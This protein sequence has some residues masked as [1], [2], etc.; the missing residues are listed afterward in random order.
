MGDDTECGDTTSVLRLA[1]EE[2]TKRNGDRLENDSKDRTALSRLD[3]HC[4]DPEGTSAASSKNAIK[5]GGNATKD[6]RNTAGFKCT[7][8]AKRFLRETSLKRHVESTH[9]VQCD[10]CAKVFA[11]RYTL[12]RHRRLHGPKPF[13]CSVCEKTFTFSYYLQQHE[14]RHQIT[15]DSPPNRHVHCLMCDTTYP[16]RVDL[17]HH[18]KSSHGAANAMNATTAVRLRCSICSKELTS[19]R[20]L[21]VHRLIHDG[22]RP[23][24]CDKCG[25]SFYD[26][27]HLM[28]HCKQH[29]G[30][31][32]A[33][34]LCG[35][36]FISPWQ[37]RRHK[38]QKHKCVDSETLIIPSDRGGADIAPV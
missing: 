4:A 9:D 34:E 10:V 36:T 30:E 8:C 13:K 22:V 21:R 16:S 18:Q 11:H 15:K 20:G 19:S 37:V 33:C 23:F 38:Q 28:R 26:K 24:V 31:R 5:K 12:S 7:K 17:W 29:S 2:T 6:S 25:A 27:C 1:P 3:D 32:V 14:M 35:K